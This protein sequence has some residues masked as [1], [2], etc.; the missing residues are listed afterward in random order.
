MR[1]AGH[2]ASMGEMRNACNILVGKTG[3]KEN[4]W[5]TPA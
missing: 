5:E 2:V 3:W 1:Y 4:K